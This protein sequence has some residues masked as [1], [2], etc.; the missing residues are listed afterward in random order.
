M[1]TTHNNEK[2]SRKIPRSSLAVL[3]DYFGFTYL[4]ITLSYHPYHD[5]LIDKKNDIINKIVEIFCAVQTKV[6]K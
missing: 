6:S 5:N 3:A 4:H 1:D 2:K